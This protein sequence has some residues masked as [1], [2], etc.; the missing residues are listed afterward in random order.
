LRQQSL[1]RARRSNQ[2]DVRFLNLNICAAAGQFNSLVMLIDR[3]REPFLGL[4][5]PDYV[6]VEERLYFIWFGKRRP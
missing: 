1:A 6:F 4:V 5:L 3:D 2:R